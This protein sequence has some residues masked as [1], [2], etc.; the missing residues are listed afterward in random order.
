MSGSVC[1]CVSERVTVSVLVCGDDRLQSDSQT[2]V[3]HIC[4][5]VNKQ[6]VSM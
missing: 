2:Q 4:A 6:G 5:C 1:V 3:A